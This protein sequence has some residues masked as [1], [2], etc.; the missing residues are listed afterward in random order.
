MG[1]GKGGGGGGGGGG[2][3]GLFKLAMNEVDRGR[4]GGGDGGHLSF[5][6][7]GEKVCFY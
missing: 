7:L 2:G 3:E 6:R 1:G 4:G 5:G